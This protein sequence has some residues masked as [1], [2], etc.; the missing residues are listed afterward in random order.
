MAETIRPFQTLHEVGAECTVGKTFSAVDNSL[1][2]GITGNLAPQYN[3]HV[4]CQSRSLP[5]RL[6]FEPLIA[7]IAATAGAELV[8][9]AFRVRQVSLSLRKTPML[10]QTLR[11]T[12]RLGKGRDAA[13][14]VVA[15]VRDASSG[16]I[17]ADVT[18]LY[19][20]L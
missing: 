6:L 14:E 17:V 10:G 4:Y 9:E 5:E 8:G 12:A 19:N 18:L 1:F 2:A 20:E 3:D 13:Y 15:T 11:A 16:E 7:G